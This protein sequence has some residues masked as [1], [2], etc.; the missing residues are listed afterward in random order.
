MQRV[1][2]KKKKKEKEKENKLPFCKM[3]SEQ[4]HLVVIKNKVM[5]WTK[6]M[7]FKLK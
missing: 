5:Q 6:W 1:S 4:I 3:Q 2:K 7:D